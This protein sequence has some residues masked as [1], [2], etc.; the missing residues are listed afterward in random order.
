MDR[1]SKARLSLGLDNPSDTGEPVTMDPSD[2][3][4]IEPTTLE[5]LREK[6]DSLSKGNKRIKE[7]LNK[8]KRE[9]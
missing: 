3:L 7:E 4:T 2:E 9:E 1:I 5:G 6:V 8:P